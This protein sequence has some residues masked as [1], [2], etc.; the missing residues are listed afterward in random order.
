MYSIDGDSWTR[1]VH[2]IRRIEFGRTMRY[3]PLSRDSTVLEL[4]CGDGF[5]LDLLRERFGRVF[6]VDPE[7][8][9]DSPGGGCNVHG[10]SL[11]L[12]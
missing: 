5:Q 10:G 8:I 12:P 11:T 9:P 3:V 6:A 7:A 1:W 4:G 2:E